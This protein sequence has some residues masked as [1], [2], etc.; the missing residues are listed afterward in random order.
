[1]LRELRQ[2]PVVLTRKEFALLAIL[3]QHPDRLPTQPRLLRKMWGPSHTEDAH[4]LRVLV[5]RLRH[6]L[7]DDAAA[8]RYIV[9]EPGVGLT[10]ATDRGRPA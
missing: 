4:Y 6:R 8:P 5:A 10:F 7:G 2:W 3:V 1:M 9:T